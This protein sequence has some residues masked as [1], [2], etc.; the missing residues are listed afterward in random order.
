MNRKDGGIALMV[1][2]AGLL[3]IVLALS[4][5]LLAGCD[6]VDTPDSVIAVTPSSTSVAAKATKV[7]TANP[8]NSN[9]VLN[10]PLEWSVSDSSLGNIIASEGLNAVYLAGTATG[11]NIITVRD[12]GEAMGIAVVNQ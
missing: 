9:A 12:Q 1:L 7:F 4:G 11:N 10:L 2:V 8:A 5:L 3:S 6:A